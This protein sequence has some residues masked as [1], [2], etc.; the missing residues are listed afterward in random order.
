MNWFINIKKAYIEN[1]EQPF[2][3]NSEPPGYSLKQRQL[4]FPVKDPIKKVD[5]KKIPIR[6]EDD[7]EGLQLTN[8]LQKIDYNYPSEEDEQMLISMV[9]TYKPKILETMQAAIEHPEVIEPSYV[10]GMVYKFSQLIQQAEQVVK[11]IEQAIVYNA[12][13]TIVTDALGLGNDNEEIEI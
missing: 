11:P 6:K 4:D 13:F 8:D 5:V 1:P 2:W 9:E 12:I 3:S 7:K 10:D